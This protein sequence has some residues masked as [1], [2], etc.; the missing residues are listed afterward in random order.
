MF[1][2]S[3][4]LSTCNGVAENG[5]QQSR[6]TNKFQSLILPKA[7]FEILVIV[8]IFVSGLFGITEAREVHDLSLSQTITNVLIATNLLFLIYI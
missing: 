1:Q 7:E 8:L 6:V 2:I 4:L 5:L 3:F